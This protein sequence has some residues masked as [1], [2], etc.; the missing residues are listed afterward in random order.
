MHVQQNVKIKYLLFLLIIFISGCDVNY[1]IN[2]DEEFITENIDLCENIDTA[3][4]KR[5]IYGND[6][7]T[8]LLLDLQIG[9]EHYNGE[10]VVKDSE[11]VCYSYDEYEH[12]HENYQYDTIAFQ[13]YDEIKVENNGDIINIEATGFNCFDYFDDLENVKINLKTIYPVVESNAKSI[14]KDTYI[15]EFD[16]NNLNDANI[17]IVLKNK[18]KVNVWNYIAI[19]SGFALLGL[20]I[21]LLVKKHKKTNNL[22]N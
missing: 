1:N 11:N 21:Y 20:V 8:D 12:L 2:I 22:N 7:Y 9:Y 14:E 19:F 17:N 5:T 4:L 6:Y 10:I 13:C 3:K 15:W 16:R 18:L